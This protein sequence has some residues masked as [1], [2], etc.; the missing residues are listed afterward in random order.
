MRAMMMI[1]YGGFD[2]LDHNEVE[3]IVLNIDPPHPSI[4]TAQPS[5]EC[6]ASNRIDVHVNGDDDKYGATRAVMYQHAWDSPRRVG[7]P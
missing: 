5:F 6:W 4:Q 2:D 3:D 1:G 7:P